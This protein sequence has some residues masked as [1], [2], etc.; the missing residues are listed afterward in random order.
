MLN[1]HIEA[2]SLGFALLSVGGVVC[3]V[4]P[5]AIFGKDHET[6][7]TDGSTLVVAC[8]LFGAAAQSLSFLSMR[9][10][11]QIHSLVVTNYTLFTAS[12][13]SLLWV[14]LVEKVREAFGL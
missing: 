11:K 3:I 10:L 13:L 5:I 9:H 2:V 7:A 12:L 4:R 6:S 1:E 14:L 8:A